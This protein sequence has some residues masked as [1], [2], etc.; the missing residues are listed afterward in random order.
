[1]LDQMKG[2]WNESPKKETKNDFGIRISLA[3]AVLVLGIVS[4]AMSIVVTGFI[5]GLVGVILGIVSLGGKYDGKAMA[6]WGLGLSVTGMLTSC[7]FGLI[8]VSGYL[9]EDGGL[10]LGQMK[11]EK[12]TVQD[13]IGKSAPDF[14]VKDVEG[15][16]I[17]LSG[18]RGKPV[19]L[20]FWW[21]SRLSCRDAIDHFIE[22]RKSMS[23]EELIILGISK[24]DVDEIQGVGRKLGVNYPLVSAADLPSPYSEVF[25]GP[26][27]F[28][29]DKDGAIRSIL[30]KYHSLEKLQEFSHLQ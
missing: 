2:I 12:Q 7:L 29:I 15:K 16:D 20:N 27:T 9:S 21:P 17:K 13:W 25:P 28:F 19:V 24:A 3:V 8:Y 1:M 10:N 30:E 4:V 11:S 5:F 23:E 26:T 14:T 22:L 18:M 6:G